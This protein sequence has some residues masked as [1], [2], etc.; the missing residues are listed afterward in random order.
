MEVRCFFLFPGHSTIKFVPVLIYYEFAFCTYASHPWKDLLVW[1]KAAQE[2]AK[3]DPAKALAALQGL[4]DQT[5]K[6][7]FSEGVILRK[8][9]QLEHAIQVRRK[10]KGWENVGSGMR[11]DEGRRGRGGT[12]ECFCWCHVLYVFALRPL[13]AA[14]S[15]IPI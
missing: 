14:W 5:A 2:F 9:A 15:S 11:I 1:D 12:Q 6:V 3:G 4:E 8:L 7:L 10:R 13:V